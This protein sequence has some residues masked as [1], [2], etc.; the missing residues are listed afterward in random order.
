LAHSEQTVTLKQNRV[1]KMKEKIPNDSFP[2]E[3]PGESLYEKES[4]EA[5]EI[6]AKERATRK[7]L[8]KPKRKSQQSD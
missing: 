2:F 8:T 1:E 6:L 4:R 3:A 5:E 7:A